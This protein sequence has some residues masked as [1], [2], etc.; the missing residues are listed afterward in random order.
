MPVQRGS[1][2]F[3]RFRVQ[4][5][6]ARPK[7]VKRWLSRA[8]RKRPFEN[9]DP[10]AEDDVS[11]GW[12]EIDN[13]DATELAASNIVFGEYALVSY[14]IDKIAV[15]KQAVK[16]EVDAFARAYFEEHGNKAPRVV[17][18][19]QKDI[20]YKKLKRRAFVATRTY[21]VSY[22]L[23]ND[24]LQIWAG[25]Q[26]LVEEIQIALEEDLHVGLHA[27]TPSTLS[28]D[29]GFP[30]EELAPTAE[31][32]NAKFTNSEASSHVS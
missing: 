8:F 14:R 30:P 32:V 24:V 6:E 3:R 23:T 28:G 2:T 21:D 22:N 19:D 7:D 11:A 18:R 27:L 16:A 10:T 4:S 12:V 25:S 13:Q 31:L 17:L 5:E 20:V 1:V 26:R 29:M 15:P 9:V